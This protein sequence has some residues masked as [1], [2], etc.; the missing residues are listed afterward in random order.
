MVGTKIRE[1]QTEQIASYNSLDGAVRAVCHLVD[2]DYPPEEIAIA[3]KR[4][5][6]VDR[7]RLAPLLRHGLGVGATVAAAV[8][9]VVTLVANLGLAT[10][11]DSVLVPTAI[12][13][14]L[15]A[16]GGAAIELFRRHRERVTHWGTPPAE[17]EPTSFDVVVTRDAEV[18][19]HDLA[20]WWDPRA[21]PASP[22]G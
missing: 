11:V 20:R 2:L 21:Q 16:V 9:I 5:H 17:L 3:P 15:G 6:A 13:A 4:F 7:D 14:A 12:A 19:G 8:T 10:L 1:N 22:A 18:A